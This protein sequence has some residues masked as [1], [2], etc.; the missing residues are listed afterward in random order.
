MS[1][2]RSE[3][4]NDQAVQSAKDSV[5]SSERILDEA[6]NK[7]EKMERMQYHEEQIWSDTIR[8][9]STWV[10]FGLMG[11]NILLLL[12]TMGVVE[13]WRRKRMVGEIKRALEE[14]KVTAV[15]ATTI[16]KAMEEE[17]DRVIEPKGVP[18]E[19]FHSAEP[20]T[21]STA[22]LPALEAETP[23]ADIPKES[24]ASTATPDNATPSLETFQEKVNDLFSTRQITLRKADVSAIALEGA[25][26]GVA[27]ATIVFM[28]LLGPR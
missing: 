20:V 23:L 5:S 27:I 28:M 1:L 21:K 7:L 4:L 11:V 10:T 14:N 13:P 16:E 9:N 12:V 22:S 3:H 17:V 8:R 26:A 24:V 18:L 6:R 25:A 2:I 19:A 15:A